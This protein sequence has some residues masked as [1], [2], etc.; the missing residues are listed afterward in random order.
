MKEFDVVVVGAGFAGMYMLYR[1]RRMGLSVLVIETADDV[2]GTWYWNRYPGARCDVPTMEYSYSFS[3]ELEQQWRWPEVMSAQPEILEYANHVAD[4]FDLRRDIQFCTRVTSAVFDENA[5]RWEVVTDRDK[6][7]RCRFCIM[8]T[9]CL[10]APNVPDFDGKDEFEGSS[11]HTGLWPKDAVDF[12]GKQVAIIGTGSSGVQ[13]IPVIAEEAL[14]LTVFQRT[15][16]YTFPANN[17]PL[18]TKTESRYKEN[19]LQVRHM[20]RYSPVGMSTFM[21]PKPN[22][23]APP[24]SSILDTSEEERREA[25]HDIGFSAFRT[26]SDVYTNIEANEVACN[27]YRDT[28]E[29]LVND[30]DVAEKL[31]PR[32]YPIGCKRQ[33]FD[34]D[35]YEAFNRDNVTLVDLTANPIECITPLGLRTRQDEYKFDILIYATGFDAMT[36]ALNKIDI[37]GKQGQTLVNKWA[38]GPVAYLGLQVH[39]FPNLFTIT[40]PGSP[41]VLSNVLVSIEQHVEWISDCIEYLGKHQIREIEP[42]TDA[43]E[44]WVEHV[45]Q[46]AK[47]TMFTAPT[48]NSWYLGANIPGKTRV[49]MPYVGGVGRYRKKCEEVVTSNYEGFTLSPEVNG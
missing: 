3:E 39:G 49:F 8:A 31:K 32:G 21:L 46:V 47:G 23:D 10:S 22:P 45:N 26:Y 44:T 15:P 42:T 27:L 37:R 34:T 38:D 33:V 40:G 6:H 13:A 16:V 12:N 4:R 9:G 5:S 30:P 11:Y 35:Y 14:H 20:Q 43:E 41:S 2:G 28:V 25:L 17:H 19:Y 18:N 36:G 7:Y 29:Q 1:L 48:C 24:P